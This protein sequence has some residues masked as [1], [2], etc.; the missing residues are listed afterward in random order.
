MN[1]RIAIST[2]LLFYFGALHAQAQ[3]YSEQTRELVGQIPNDDGQ[4]DWDQ[5]SQTLQSPIRAEASF[6]DAYIA[7]LIA[8]RSNRTDLVV[9]Y[10]EAAQTS[11]GSNVEQF[12][13]A[14][15]KGVL[16]FY[17]DEMI[18]R[19][20]AATE[21]LM[22]VDEID[23][24]GGAADWLSATTI[25]ALNKF[26]LETNDLALSV[27][28]SER[29]ER[30]FSRGPTAR[31]AIWAANQHITAAYAAMP[32]PPDSKR[33][34]V[35]GLLKRATN[36]LSA[37]HRRDVKPED[38]DALKSLYYRTIALTLYMNSRARSEDKDSIP[39]PY[40]VIKDLHPSFERDCVIELTSDRRKVRPRL[41]SITGG[42]LLRLEIDKK[43]RA[44]FVR[45]EDAVPAHLS[46]EKMHRT[47]RTIAREIRADLNP[48]EACQNGG[49]IL[50]PFT[51]SSGN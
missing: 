43:G 30:I 14:L 36:L 41:L 10:T 48:A 47:Y 25:S 4:L 3:S 40:G 44:K 11:A 39:L 17:L 22:T 21:L 37:A 26:A 28:A 34:T 23:S 15:L 35:S 51:I 42:I 29:A 7:A 27:E 20:E 38:V 16:T 46:N 2:A 5:L 33:E 9:E 19:R 18:D 8:L 1:I 50:Y 6:D 24:A 12:R 32:S 45:V 31:I 13:A 49:E